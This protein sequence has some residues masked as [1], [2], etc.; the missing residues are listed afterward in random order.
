M[1]RVDFEHFGRCRPGV[2]DGFEGGLPPNS[3]EVLGEIVCRHESKNVGLEAFEVG[4]VERLDGRFLDR[5]VHAFGLAVGSWMVRLGKLVLDAVLGT[6][7]VED[8]S[9]KVSS[10]RS[11]PVLWQV[12]EGHSVID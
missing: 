10:G 5:P 1:T 9:T 4:I 7:T 8:V 6:E 3:F 2:A 11:I 12:G